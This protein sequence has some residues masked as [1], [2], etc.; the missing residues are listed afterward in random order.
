MKDKE[1]KETFDAAEAHH[2]LRSFL[3]LR[4]NDLGLLCRAD[5]RGE[6]VIQLSPPLIAGPE[7]F[8]IMNSVLRKALTEAM[9]EMERHR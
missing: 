1:T 2:L 9:A 5:S 7:E 3:S 8:E 6:P 4:L